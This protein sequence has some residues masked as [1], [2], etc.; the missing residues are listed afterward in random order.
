MGFG[1]GRG[2]SLPN[3]DFSTISNGKN[4]LHFNRIFIMILIISFSP[5]RNNGVEGVSRKIW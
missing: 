4:D 1:R 2:K 5:K 3:D